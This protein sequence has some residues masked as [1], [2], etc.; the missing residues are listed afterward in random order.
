MV[1]QVIAKEKEEL[2]IK[3]QVRDDLIAELRQKVG[4]LKSAFSMQFGTSIS[5]PSPES[6]SGGPNYVPGSQQVSQSMSRTA[7]K[8]RYAQEMA[9][10]LHGQ[11]SP[12]TTP[13]RFTNPHGVDAPLG[14]LCNQQWQV[15]SPYH[16][17]SI[18]RNQFSSRTMSGASNF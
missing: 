9:R 5:P 6:F 18:K 7:H 17:R 4:R 3:V 12:V 14:S 2:L 11:P 13:G 1:K 16:S 15:G 8:L 10:S